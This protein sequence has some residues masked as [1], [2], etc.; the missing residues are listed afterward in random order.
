MCFDSVSI[1]SE[2]ESSKCTSSCFFFDCVSVGEAQEWTVLHADTAGTG[3][4]SAGD[5]R[6]GEHAGAEG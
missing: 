4:I 5:A 6:P 1:N 2:Q 3:N